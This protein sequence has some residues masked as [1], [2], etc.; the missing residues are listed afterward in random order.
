MAHLSHHEMMATIAQLDHAIHSH[1]QWYKA[2][3]RTM[4]AHLPP[5]PGDLHPDAH[6]RCRLGHWYESPATIPLRSHPAFEALGHAHVRM[7]ASA[8]ALLRASKDGGPVAADA[9]DHFDGTLERMRL[10]IQS[11]RRELADAVQNRDALTGARN[12]V[13]LLPDLREQQALIRRGGSPCTLAMIDLDHFK[14]VNDRHGH[15]AGDAV[16]VATVRCLQGA[17]RPYDRLYR[18]GGEEFLLC[19]PHVALVPAVGVTERLRGAISAIRI[20]W[21]DEGTKL[22]VTASFGVAALDATAPVEDSID[23]ADRLLYK[24][25]QG[26]RNRV[27]MGPRAD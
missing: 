19:M 14:L 24:S 1:E 25:K 10:E 7:H 9:L 4:V 23:L 17:L 6:R 18:Y 8:S 11:L 2:L 13:G 12:R 5:D 16:L 15:A 3:V 27:S 22:Q 20:P 26:G 21:G